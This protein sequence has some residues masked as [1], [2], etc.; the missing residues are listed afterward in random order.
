MNHFTKN[1]DSPR[2]KEEYDTSLWFWCG[3][4][5][6]AF[7]HEKKN[8][9]IFARTETS[10]LP[11]SL[12]HEVHLQDVTHTIYSTNNDGSLKQASASTNSGTEKT[13]LIE[14]EQ[15]GVFPFSIFLI[16]VVVTNCFMV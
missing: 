12:Q 3:F 7:I 6:V 1:I 8:P 14:R 9:I 15:V 16:V 5:S 4:Y 10:H 2:S 11:K 13:T